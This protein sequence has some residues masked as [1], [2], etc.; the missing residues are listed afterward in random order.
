MSQPSVRHPI[1]D[2]A[3][4]AS[5]ECEFFR[6]ALMH[7]PIGVFITTPSGR[8]TFANHA[9][10]RILGYA[11]PDE[12]MALV[13]DISTQVYCDP[14]DRDSFL[15]QLELC[16]ELGNQEGRVRRKDGSSSG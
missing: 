7:S 1:D 6:D 3:T 14:A 16:D 2:S 8:F 15:R 13:T 10:A 5:M 4:F 11:S 12:L 9:M